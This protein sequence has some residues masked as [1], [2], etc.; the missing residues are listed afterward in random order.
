MGYDPNPIWPNRYIRPP[1]QPGPDPSLL[2]AEHE[3]SHDP[4]EGQ[5][6]EPDDVQPFDAQALGSI[7]SP[8][9]LKVSGEGVIIPQGNF[10]GVYVSPYGASLPRWRPAVPGRPITYTKVQSPVVAQAPGVP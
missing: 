5:P 7:T 3:H 2:R 10:T 1:H 4:Y 8:N 6:S 9:S